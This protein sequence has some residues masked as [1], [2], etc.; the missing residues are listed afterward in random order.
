MIKL[1]DIPIFSALNENYLKELQQLIHVK[2]Y[3]KDSIVFYEADES[4]VCA[5][6]D[7]GGCKTL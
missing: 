4:D 6:F 1:Q 7:G 5:Y 3:T 2:K